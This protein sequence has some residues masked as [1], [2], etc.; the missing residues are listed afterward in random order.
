MHELVGRAWGRFLIIEERGRGGMAVVYRA[1]DNVLQ[2]TVA[3]KVLLP[4][5]AANVEFTRRFER[6]AITA[7]NLRHPN[8]VVI[9]DVGSHESFQYIVMEYLEGL[10]LQQE[11][12][13]KGALPTGRVISIVGQ[14]ASALDYAHL[15]GLVHRDIKPA[16]VIIGAS[17]PTGAGDR[18]TLTD[19][20]LVKAARLGAITNE[21]MTSGTLNYMSPEQAMGKEMDGRSDIYSLGVVV[22]EMLAGEVPFFATTPYQVLRDLIQEAPPPMSRINQVVSPRVEQVVFRALAKEPDKRFATAGEFA[23]ALASVTGF[24]AVIQ[25]DAQRQRTASFRREIVFYLIASDG[26]QYPVYRGEVTIGR[27]TGNDVVLPVSQVSRRHARITCDR[28]GYRVT[29]LGSTNG[30]F[31][32]GVRLQIGSSCPLRPDDTLGIGPIN[33]QALSSAP[34]DYA[35]GT[36]TLEIDHRK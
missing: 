17:S 24:G 3:L 12:Q 16:N 6:E 26:R 11:I 25:E 9:Y 10:T 21:G 30:T 22:Y 1:Y 23:V 28:E 31:V 4:H 36:D 8:I 7:A 33:L 13:K 2:R 20:G 29:D 15:Q 32:N 19:F 14:L 35:G 5:L 27:D 18:V 34:G